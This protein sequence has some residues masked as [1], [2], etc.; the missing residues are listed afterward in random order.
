MPAWDT[1]LDN[2]AVLIEHL[3]TVGAMPAQRRETGAEVN[4]RPKSV[5][6]PDQR[7]TSPA[8]PSRTAARAPLITASR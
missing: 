5:T 6:G 4:D 7:S 2:P 3:R 1:D 8:V